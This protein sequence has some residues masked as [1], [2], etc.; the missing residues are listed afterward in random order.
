MKLKCPCCGSS[1]SIDALI[2]HDDARDALSALVALGD[3]LLKGVMRYIG[4]FRPEKSDLSFGRV[5]KLI[6]EIL[7]DIR[8][9]QIS[10]D[11][12]LYPAPTQAWMWAFEQ[13]VTARNY[14]SLKT[15]L[16]GHGYLYE[17]ISHW[18]GQGL[19]EVMPEAQQATQ[20]PQTQTGKGLASLEALRRG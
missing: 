8:S 17:V 10:R 14:G 6:N 2:G 15:P 13:A 5:A 3:G 11:G 1:M 9:G 18:N 20:K 7:P 16:K 19:P 12:K 4:L